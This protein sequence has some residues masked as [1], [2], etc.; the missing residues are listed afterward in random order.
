MNENGSLPVHIASGEGR[1]E[2]IQDFLN[3]CPDSVFLLNSQGQNLLHV[4]AE[5]GKYRVVYYCLKSNCD[6]FK[7]LIN[8]TDIDGNTPLHLAIMK[9]QHSTVHL[10]EQDKRVDSNLTNNEG[11]TAKAAKQK[12]WDQETTP[13]EVCS[14]V[15]IYLSNAIVINNN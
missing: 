9:K 4:A 6:R 12:Y 10:L 1:L 5:K 2:I 3:L 8:A 13:P 7:R 14:S 11:L 15:I